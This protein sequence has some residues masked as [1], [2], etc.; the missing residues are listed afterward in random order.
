MSRHRL[1]NDPIG[2]QILGAF[3]PQGDQWRTIGGIARTTGL[4]VDTVHTYVQTHEMN[5]GQA[6]FSPGGFTLYSALLS[7]KSDPLKR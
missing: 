1:F 7:H 3:G 4:P 6:P 5:F 2:H